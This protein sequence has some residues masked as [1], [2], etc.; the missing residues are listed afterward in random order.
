MVEMR[1]SKGGGIKRKTDSEP[2]GPSGGYS[3]GSTV[4]KTTAR[5][6]EW[7]GRHHP[8]YAVTV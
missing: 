8:S 6:A 2:A 5:P 7:Q 4:I 3:S 1:D